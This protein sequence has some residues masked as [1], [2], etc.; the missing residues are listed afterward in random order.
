MNPVEARGIIV[1]QLKVVL[2]LGA[3]ARETPLVY[4]SKPSQW[5]QEVRMWMERS[6]GGPRRRPLTFEELQLHALLCLAEANGLTTERLSWLDAGDLLRKAMALD[7]H[8]DPSLLGF[9]EDAEAEMRRRL[10]ATVLELNALLSLQ[11]AQPPLISPANWTT[12]GPSE[13]AD[14][15]LFRDHITTSR[16]AST[17]V[18]QM[19]G[20]AQSVLFSSFRLRLE[21]ASK[22]SSTAADLPYNERLRL[23]SDLARA[24]AQ[25]ARQ[26]SGP[27]PRS[28]DHESRRPQRAARI[29]LAR[30]M[31]ALQLP[32]L[33][34]SIKDPAF[35][36]SRRTSIHTALKMLK[37][38]DITPMFP[39]IQEPAIQEESILPGARQPVFVN[40]AGLF[41]GVAIQAVFAVL[42]ELVTFSE[43]KIEGDGTLPAWE[44]REV[45]EA[46]LW[47]QEWIEMRGRKGLPD[48]PSCCFVAGCIAYAETLETGITS[49]QQ[50]DDRMVAAGYERCKRYH[51]LLEG[52]YRTLEECTADAI[53][54]GS[55]TQTQNGMDAAQEDDNWQADLGLGGGMDDFFGFDWSLLP[56]QGMF[57]DSI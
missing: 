35:H 22:T 17:A 18:D 47:C 14:D 53:T 52:A 44:P 25:M 40:S 33:G 36:F 37:W 20:S 21:V 3:S 12:K 34:R 9:Q 38:C 29:I 45:R 15:E 26:F 55:G 24:E 31:L 49:T 1:L 54:N 6:A 5:V 39:T 13:V 7:L 4:G 28:P 8:E 56:D 10:W 32:L 48:V 30:Y 51:E 41:R 2:A 23:Q 27:E 42:L 16:G 19:P 43:E 46:A 57:L 50:I 11:S